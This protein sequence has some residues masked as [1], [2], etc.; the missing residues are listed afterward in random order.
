MNNLQVSVDKSSAIPIYRQIEESIRR[1]IGSGLLRP[2]DRLPSEN[3]L[4]RELNI[5][6]MTIRQAMNSLVHEGVIYR[7]RG[8]GTFVA[9]RHIE[10]P[11]THMVG[12]SEDMRALGL[13]PGS[14]ILSFERISAPDSVAQLLKIEVGAPVL[15]I[16]R[17]RSANDYPVGVHN[18]FLPGLDVDRNEL[19]QSGS[20]Y[21]LFEQNGVIIHE[22]L[23]EI[24]AIAADDEMHSLLHVPMKTPLLMVQ[25]VSFTE[26]KQP[27]ELV[28]AIYRSDFY[29]YKIQ[30]KR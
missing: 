3:E 11:L 15:H 25:R 20:L 17:L 23:D 30:L 18:T 27:V 21:Q 26:T 12:F 13:R 8:K 9:P 10:H 28:Y 19:E 14:Q 24:E 6:P 1:S 2:Y 5:S 22:S 4:T 29:R 16:R 7:E